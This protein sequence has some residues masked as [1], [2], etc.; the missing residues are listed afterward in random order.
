MD[1]PEIVFED[2]SLL[3]LNKPAGWVVNRVESTKGPTVQD[4]VDRKSEIRL[5]AGEAGN[6]KFESANE[7][8][9]RSGIVHRLDKETS[10]LLLVAKTPEA[11]INLQK[12]FAERR[13]KK[14]Y[15][16]LVHGKMDEKGTIEAEVGRLPWRRDRF[17][18]LPGGRVAKTGYRTLQLLTFPRGKAGDRQYFSLV[19]LSPETGRTHQIRV[20]LK[21]VGHPVVSDEFY[22]GRKTARNDR[23]WCPRLFLH[24]QYLGFFHPETGKWMEFNS[25]LPPDLKAVLGKLKSV[26]GI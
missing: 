3:V 21:S 7:F 11:F 15:L 4:W 14:K 25:E 26:F 8:F 5:P 13:V 24:A 2:S 22:A 17:G 20:H 16:A 18:V 9:D 10:G 1:Q 12:Q 6:S 23:K 19:E